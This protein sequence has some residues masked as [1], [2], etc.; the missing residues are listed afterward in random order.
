MILAGGEG[1]RLRPLTASVPKPIVRLVDRPFIAFML[2]CNDMIVC[3]SEPGL[4]IVPLLFRS[5]TRLIG[6]GD[7]SFQLCHFGAQL[8]LFLV[9][10]TFRLH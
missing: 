2:E 5:H 10:V 3:L 4:S 6:C 8:L 1:R 7:G 9:I